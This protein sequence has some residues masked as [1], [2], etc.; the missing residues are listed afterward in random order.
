MMK[1]ENTFIATIH[2][3]R[4]GPDKTYSN[5]VVIDKCREYCDRVGLCVSVTETTYVYTG[6]SEPGSIV[7]LIQYPRFPRA[8]GEIRFFATE[9]AYRLKHS[10]NQK[11]C[12]IIFPDKTITIGELDDDT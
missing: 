10:L 9:L 6:G 1:A 11:R 5:E 12:S 3:G 2:V 8:E 4:R 7:G